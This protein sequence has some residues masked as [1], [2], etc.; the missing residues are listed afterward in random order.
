MK[1]C[2][3]CL[4]YYMTDIVMVTTCPGGCQWNEGDQLIENAITTPSELVCHGWNN[5]FLDQKTRN[6]ARTEQSPHQSNFSTA[7]KQIILCTH[8]SAS[9]VIIFRQCPQKSCL[10]TI[11]ITQKAKLRIEALRHIFV[12]DHSPKL[13]WW[14]FRYGRIAWIFI[15]ERCYH[16]LYFA[17]LLVK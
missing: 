11:I 13:S 8:F 3:S 6:W 10:M 1:H 5:L 12:C 17:D 16:F 2:V 7:N 9:Q 4:I 14:Q 15:K